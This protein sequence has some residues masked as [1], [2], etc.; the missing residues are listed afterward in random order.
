M[1]MHREPALF[2]LDL[3][4]ATVVEERTI[5]PESLLKGLCIISYKCYPAM[6]SLK[7]TQIAHVTEVWKE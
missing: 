7:Q 1:G 6:D 4:S 5:S 2:Y 3:L